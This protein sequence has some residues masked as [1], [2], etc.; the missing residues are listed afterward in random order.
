MAG[1]INQERAMLNHDNS[2]DATNE[3]T[4]QRVEP[5]IPQKTSQSWQ[6]KAH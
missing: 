4:S 3:K 1:R 2:R 6:T 5:A